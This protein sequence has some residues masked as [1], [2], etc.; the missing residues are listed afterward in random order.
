VFGPI[1]NVSGLSDFPVSPDL[2]IDDGGDAVIAWSLRP[3]PFGPLHAQFRALS[4]AGALGPIV[5]LS[6][7]LPVQ[8][9]KVAMNSQGE[10]FFVW[11]RSN[12][13]QETSGARTFCS[14]RARPDSAPFPCRADDLS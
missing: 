3:P 7:V 8:S 12:E 5:N 6:N 2:A 10:A 4:A 13:S 1:R 9:P 11:V 14:R